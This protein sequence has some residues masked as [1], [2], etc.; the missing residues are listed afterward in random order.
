MKGYSKF[1]EMAM[2]GKKLD[3]EYILDAHTHIGGRSKI[4]HL[5]DSSTD[6]MVA[7]MDR[8]GIDLAIT[9]PFSGITSDF[10]F[11][12]DVTSDGVNRYPDRFVGF[13]CCNPH[14]HAEMKDELE[15]CKGMGLR[16]IKLIAGY[17]RYPA[18]GPGLFPAYEY[19]HENCWPI[20]NHNWGTPKFLDKLASTFSNACFVIG[21]FSLAY[22]VVVLA[23][24]NVFQCTCAALNFGDIE[25]LV[26]AVPPDKIVYGSDF[27]DLP[28]MFSMAP[29]LYARISDDDKRKILGLTAKTVLDRWPGQQP[30][31]KLC[32]PS[33]K[34]AS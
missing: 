1:R 28:I 8:H 2:L 22:A 5:P 33:H 12:N 15:R 25:A 19:A 6:E 21:H 27:T 30:P 11:G 32:K 18:E 31:D 10:A 34:A 29:I 20:L 17:Q 4:Y 26:D 13:A 23:H 14:Y 7:E 16:G 24:D 9:F 3:G